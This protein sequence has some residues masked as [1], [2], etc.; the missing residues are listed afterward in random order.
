MRFLPALLLIAA[1]LLAQDP[2][3]EER[4]AEEAR[5]AEAE[6]AAQDAAD[7][8]RA[9]MEAERAAK[10]WAERA[11]K[12]E[13]DAQA[14]PY[15]ERAEELRK[16]AEQRSKWGMTEQDLRR[17]LDEL[18]SKSEEKRQEAME[19]IKRANAS[20]DDLL[21]LIAQAL[22]TAERARG[23]FAVEYANAVAPRTL[24]LGALGGGSE[25]ISGSADGTDYTLKSLGEG[26]YEL[27]ATKRADDGKVMEE[28]KDQGT[29]KELQEKYAFLKAGLAIQYPAAV[30]V[31][32]RTFKIETAPLRAWAATAVNESA[33]VPCVTW[34][35]GGK[36]GVQVTE[37]S[38]DLRF[39]LRLPEGAGFI[40]RDVAA[41]SRAEQIGIRR[42]DVLLRL[43]GELI[44]SPLQLKKLH[45]KKGVLEILRRAETKKIDLATVAEEPA[46]KAAELPPAEPAPSAPAGAR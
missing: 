15:A 7:A 40:V 22:E 45:E 24:F 43:D 10:A 17:F 8:E 46:E 21:P 31:R 28:T 16:L 19:A 5:R 29:L 39:H 32:P 27:T 35:G 25:V 23:A 42:M 36:V 13:A 44:D 2:T 3:E 6:R 30:S 33:D 11:A 34:G 9:A 18:R 26:R 14:K 1:P 37:A 38:G 41:G 20:L 12:G 4:R